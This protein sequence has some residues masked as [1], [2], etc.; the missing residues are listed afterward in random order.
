MLDRTSDAPTRRRRRWT[1]RDGKRRRRLSRRVR[2]VLV[3]S[4]ALG[5]AALVFAYAPRPEPAADRAAATAAL[6]RS[7]VRFGSGNVSGAIAAAQTAVAED[8][9]WG[10][11]HALLGRLYLAQGDGAAGEAQVRRALETGFAPKRTYHLLAE[12]ALLQGDAE[13]A[14]AEAKKAPPRYAGYAARVRARALAAQGD[15]GA[16]EATLAPLLDDRNA[17]AWADLGAIR[18]Q[19]GDIGGAIEAAVRA[20]AIDP[21]DTRAILLRGVLV[22]GQFGPA[23]SLPWAEAALKRDPENVDALA[24]YAATLGDLGRYTDMLA[25]TR[26]AIAADPGDPRAYYLQAV[27]AARAH[28][29]DLSRALLA[30]TGMGDVPGALLLGGLLDYRDGADQ[31]AIDQWRGLISR[32]PYN[33]TARRLL[34]AALL[35]SGDEEGALRFLL[36][37]ALRADADSYTLTLTARAYEALGDREAAGRYLD[38]AAAPERGT[39]GAFSADAGLALLDAAAADSP[40]D[41]QIAVNYIGGLIEAGRMDDA[42]A[43]AQRL[44]RAAPGVPAAQLLSGDMLAVTDHAEAAAAAYARAADLRFDEPTALK[45]IAA[46]DKTAQRAEA[47]R[48][49]G[50]YLSQNPQ[51]VPARRL[52]AEWQLAAGDWD[53]AV[54]TLEGLRAAV[55]ER[56]AVLLAELSSAYLGAG[57]VGAAVPFAAA[58]HRLQPLNPAIADAYGWALF[59]A[60]KR[61]AALQLLRQAIATAPDHAGLRAHLEEIETAR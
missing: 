56:D 58:A 38:R 24:D 47:A 61:D 45:L 18:R 53:A 30:K 33:L 29:F 13:R 10:L 2:L 48:T 19:A 3:L 43:R 34:G 35:R 25:A 7:L 22:R 21:A 60:G 12:A 9:G 46:L 37:A 14:L 23:A 8:R 51:S 28:R 54:E 31:Q 5:L 42:L 40:S 4:G 41:P 57:D 6:R 27:L 36:P 49:L 52:T 15:Y 26:R 11:A 20:T 39:P 50:L 32:Q 44:A 1:N 16:A 55:G 17:A 59:K